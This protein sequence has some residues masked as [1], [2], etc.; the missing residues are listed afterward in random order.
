MSRRSNDKLA[1]ML[2]IAA[3]VAFA[4]LVAFYPLAL[5]AWTP[6]GWFWWALFGSAPDDGPIGVATGL[7]LTGVLGPACVVLWALARLESRR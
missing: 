6:C 4:L 1:G 3:V 5:V 7:V 2:A